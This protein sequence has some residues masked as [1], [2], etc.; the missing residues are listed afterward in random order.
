MRHS[1]RPIFG[2]VA[3]ICVAASC[4]FAHAGDTF[5]EAKEV[6]EA[7]AAGFDT[8]T[9]EQS[10]EWLEI[11]VGEGFDGRGTG[12]E[13]YIRAAH[14]V[15]GKLSEFGFQ[16]IG[17]NGTYFQNLPFFRVTPDLDASSVSIGDVRISGSDAL[18]FTSFSDTARAEGG[19]VLLKVS[20]NQVQVDPAKLRGKVVLL[21]AKDTD[22]RNLRGL[23]RAGAAA[24]L[25]V[26]DGEPSST[27]LTQRDGG[28]G[29]GARSISGEISAES[30]A[31]L[32]DAA[33]LDV[34]LAIGDLEG[35]EIAESGKL[36]SIDL[37]VV[38]APQT[39]P[40]VVGWMEG[41]DP[42]LKHEY[43]V[44]GGHLDHL[45]VRGESLYPGA[46]DN[47]SGSTAILQVAKAL[48]ENPVKP[49]RSVL[50]I[51]FAAEEMGLLGSQHFVENPLKP[52]ENC[53][54]MFNIDMVGR[55][56]ETEN[57]AASENVDS[58]HLIGSEQYSSDLH[59]V[60][61]GVNE[62]VGFRFEYDE[63]ENVFRRSDHYNFF[64]NDIPVAFVFGGFN[65]HYHQPSDGLNDINYEKIANCA[66]LYYLAIHK[67]SEHGPF[68][69]DK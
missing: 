60:M 47:G 33:D 12:Q 36:A 61:L 46:D 7:Y 42:D 10:M 68:T 66:R 17:D 54:C 2:V 24:I 38:R 53:I 14:F 45:G 64:K 67:V 28:R 35:V 32:L 59:K 49:A 15:A 13:G 39:V 18:G 3:A 34:D 51:A 37:K 58:I 27:T 56:E 11:L 26:V 8:I 5:G 44:I 55:N 19:I 16:P 25:R 62:H 9:E 40:N 30:A 50:Y 52:L 69:R 48:H 29:F 22:E 4:P 41:S 6:E 63:E 23:S 31:K 65:P 57:E 20:G 1:I 21:H 43:I